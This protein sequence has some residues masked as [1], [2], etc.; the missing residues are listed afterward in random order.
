MEQQRYHC[1]KSGHNSKT[2]A[3]GAMSQVVVD[4]TSKM[5]DQDLNAIATYLRSLPASPS[6]GSANRAGS[7]V[8]QTGA[9]LYVDSCAACHQANGQGVSGLF[10]SLKGSAVVQ[11]K[12]PLTMLRLVLNGGHAAKT[13]SNPNDTAMPSFGWKLSDEQIADLASYVRA[14]WGNQADSISRSDVAAARSRVAAIT[15]T[16]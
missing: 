5:T 15:S 9:A 16:K 7:R 13:L 10:P 2:V 3:Y 11:S 1:L 12:D 6:S 14:A 4:S 8:L